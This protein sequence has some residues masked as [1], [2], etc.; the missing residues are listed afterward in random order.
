[1]LSQSDSEIRANQMSFSS[2]ALRIGEEYFAKKKETL[3]G[4]KVLCCVDSYQSEIYQNDE[5]V[6]VR[7]EIIF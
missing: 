7:E 2:R 3:G 6:P 4:G 1:M 5:R